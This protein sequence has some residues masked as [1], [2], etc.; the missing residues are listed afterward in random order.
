MNKKQKVTLVRIIITAILT[1]IL[2]FLPLTG[3]IKL[4]AY[5]LTYALIGYRVIIKAVKGIISGQVLDE[6]FLMV[7]A[8]VGAFIIGFMR[9]GDYF[10]GI[11]VMFF[12]ELGEFFQTYAVNKSRKSIM[13]LMDIRP[14]YANLLKDDKITTVSPEEVQMGD[15]IVIK[16]GEKIAIDGVVIEG[17]TALNTL[18]ISGESQPVTVKV[19]DRVVSG[20]ISLSGVIKVKTTVSFN[21]STVSK[22][23]ELVESGSTVKSREEKFISKFA[24]YYT[25]VVCILALLLS[26]GVPLVR[27]ALGYGVDWAT[28]VYRGLTFLVISCPCALVISVPLSFFAG[29]GKASKKGVLIKGA[30]FIEK[31]SKIQA[32]AFD[33]TGTITKGDFTVQEIVGFGCNKEKVLHYAVLLEKSCSHP[34]AKSIVKRYNNYIDDGKVTNLTEFSGRGVTALVGKERVTVGNFEFLTEQGISVA[35]INQV[36]TTV[37][38]AVDNDCIGYIVIADGVKPTSIDGVNQLEKLGVKNLTVLS[39][40]KPEICKKVCDQ[41]GINRFYAPLLPHEKRDK[42]KEIMGGVDKGKTTA[43]VGDGI[44]DAPVLVTAEVGVSM[45]LMGSD[46]AIESSDVVIMEDNLVKLSE[47]IKISK[48]CMGIVY[49][50]IIFALAVKIACLVLGSLGIASLA[51]AIFADVGV[52]VLAVLNAVRQLV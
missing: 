43:F 7:V 29:I 34:I 35:K 26:V 1:L 8:T 6:N 40:D 37:Y 42:L 48:K 39:G 30:T 21:N 20:S 19:G 9:T 27:L 49:Q 23:I 47:A 51:L 11:A 36:Y 31:L 24:K 45:G 10:E 12:Y 50:N 52:M 4:T 17:E 28:W 41:V 32:V 14:D 5:L 13:K 38:V 3:Y 44:N 15:I 25:P 33:K 18:A 46:I 2:Q 16:A 22:I